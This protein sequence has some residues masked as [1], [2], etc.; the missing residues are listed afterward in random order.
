MKTCLQKFLLCS[1]PWYTWLHIN[2][3]HGQLVLRLLCIL[4][5]CILSL[6]VRTY[7]VCNNYVTYVAMWPYLSRLRQI[8]RQLCAAT[9]SSPAQLRVRGG[10]WE[11]EETY[12]WW[13]EADRERKCQKRAAT[14]DAT[15][16]L[17]NREWL[18]GELLSGLECWRPGWFWDMK[19]QTC[20]CWFS[21]VQHR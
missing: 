4:H 7:H 15:E 20:P 10:Y 14:H 16:L 1:R 13:H 18:P 19:Y 8:R 17:T 9:M 3:A 12:T 6:Y 11:A 5:V 21:F 2:L